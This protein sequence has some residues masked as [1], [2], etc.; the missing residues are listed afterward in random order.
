MKHPTNIPGWE[1]TLDELAIAIENMRYDKTI[2]F[3]ERLE[4]AINYRAVMDKRAGRKNLASHLFSAQVSL[5][6]LQ[7]NLRMAWAICKS[8]IENEVLAEAKLPMPVEEKEEYED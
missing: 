3:V 1:G 8:H 6:S 4:S 7:R 5:Q 2:E